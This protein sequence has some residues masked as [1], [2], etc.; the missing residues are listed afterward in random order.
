MK[1]FLAAA[2][3][4]LL[5][6]ACSKGNKLDGFEGDITMHT[7]AGTNSQ[8]MIVEVKK[9]QLR[10]DMNSPQAGAMHGVFDPK[11]NKVTLYADTTKTYTDMDFSGPSGKTN[12]SPDTSSIA[13][14]G[15]HETIAGYDCDDVTVNDPSG[16]KSEV[17][18]AQG[19]AFFDVGSLRGGAQAS[20]SAIATQFREKKSF[21]LKSVEYDASGKELSRMEVTKIESKSL[22]DSRFAPPADYT[23][24]AL[25]H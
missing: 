5:V 23:K 6:S 14:S 18:I 19:I 21:P 1:F 12:T 4:A 10:F 7:T 17:C 20:G 22:D 11:A 9:D 8:D 16:K 2:G 24:V 15:K 13:Q 25:P 3:L